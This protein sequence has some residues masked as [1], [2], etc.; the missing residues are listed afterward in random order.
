MS[1]TEKHRDALI[2]WA[3]SGY[4]YKQIAEILDCPKEVL[5]ATA[6]RYKI[7][8]KSHY[9]QVGEHLDKI[10]ELRTTHSQR[11]IAKIY[12]VSAARINQLL[13]GAGYTEF[14]DDYRPVESND[15][16]FLQRCERAANAEKF[17]Y[18][19]DAELKQPET[20]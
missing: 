3:S 8:V 16:E 9:P 4:T 13:A 20:V 18:T 10:I 15:R 19:M 7:K 11:A 14:M 12:R 1:D 17:V 2:H 6:R 5:Y